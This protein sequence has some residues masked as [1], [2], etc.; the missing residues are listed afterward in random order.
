MANYVK[1]DEEGDVIT[2][3]DADGEVELRVFT[4]YPRSVRRA[5]AEAYAFRMAARLGC[6][7]GT[8]YN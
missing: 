1:V 4:V 8:N 5:E 6:Q 7:W 3:Y 2:V